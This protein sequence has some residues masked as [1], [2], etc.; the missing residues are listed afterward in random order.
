MMSSLRTQLLFL[1]HILDIFLFSWNRTLVKLWSRTCPSLTLVIITQMSDLWDLKK[2]YIPLSL[3]FYQ[4]ALSHQSLV[5]H[6]WSSVNCHLSSVICHLS[7]VIC[8]L[9]SPDNVP[10]LNSSLLNLIQACL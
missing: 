8:H 1:N 2:S 4:K 3:L 10:V 5:I 7:S 6:H 9:S